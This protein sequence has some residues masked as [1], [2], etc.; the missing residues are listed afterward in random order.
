MASEVAARYAE[1]LFALARENG[2][3]KD[4]KD[5]CDILL[6]LYDA[7]PELIGFFRAAKITDEETKDFVER[8][9]GS[10][11]DQEMRNYIKLLIDKAREGILR[12]SL[13]EFVRLA[14]EELGIQP[15]TVWSARA[16]PETEMQQL[17]K[18]LE[19]KTGKE[20]HLTNRV[21]P[22]LIAGIKVTVGNNVTDMTM[23]S[24]IDHLKETLLKGGGQA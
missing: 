18:S 20:I 19:E 4:K 14:D 12:E 15:A 2:T 7:N 23:R 10:V 9:F 5:Q 22:D 1:G 6:K 24:R 11:T 8:I 13:N 3:V 17:K 21:N 16:L